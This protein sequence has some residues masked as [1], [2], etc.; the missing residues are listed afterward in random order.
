MIS[1][2]RLAREWALKTLYQ[3]DVGKTGLDEAMQNTQQR[4]R[5]EF[6][7]R[8]SRSAS[9]SL[10][11][12]ICLE[13]ITQAFLP[14]L[15]GM[16]P[17][18]EHVQAD[19]A[20]RIVAEAPYWMELRLER[21][22]RTRAPGVPLVPPRLLAPL[23]RSKL[24]PPPG[25]PL[26]ADF[27]S[28]PA[29]ERTRI[30]NFIDEARLALPRELDAQFKS[31]MRE[32]TKTIADGR[33]L[34]GGPG[35]VQAYLRGQREAFNALQIERWRK[36][37]VILRKQTGD[38]LRTAAFAYKLTQ[39]V[40]DQREQIDASIEA[41]AQGW[42]LERQVA[43]DRNILRMAGF[44]MLFMPGVP[45][46]ATINEAVELAK[47]YSTAESS[48]FVNGILGSL[49]VQRKGCDEGEENE[50]EEPLDLPDISSVEEE[51]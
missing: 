10:L 36:I 41:L 37:A 29:V 2:R 34:A 50:S 11:E 7:L 27:E 24:T 21:S 39:G 47:K 35:A 38:W 45:G 4:L 40:F 22:F 43:V 15:S 30:Y 8:G 31:E 3:W 9:G 16:T 20:G 49:I 28:L 42:R 5:R 19:V 33:P 26:R 17:A 23:D 32:F 46:G 44:E 48:R 6:V 18:L 12:Q 14:S 25:D 1:S 13:Y 51:E